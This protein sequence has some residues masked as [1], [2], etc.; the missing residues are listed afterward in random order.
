[1]TARHLTFAG[2]QGNALAAS[3]WPG[4]TGAPIVLFTHGGG[5]TRHAWDKTARQLAGVGLSAISIDQRGHGDS[6]WVENGAYAVSDF[7]ADLSSV[8]QAIEARFGRKPISVGASLG[9]LASMRAIVDRPDLFEALILVDITPRMDPAGVGHIQGFMRAKAREG[10][11]SIE[12]AGEAVARY[13]PHRPRP[14]SLEGLRKNLR[15]GADGRWRWHWDPLFLDGPRTINHDGQAELAKVETF[16]PHYRAPTLLV[17]GAA[18]E[19][20]TQEA[21]DQFMALVPHAAYADVADARH[22]VAGDRNDHFTQA[23]LAFLKPTAT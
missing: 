15:Q 10:F 14:S 9:G 23:V 19:L 11:A 21:V 2:R 18:S 6:A 22:M 12:E 20:V 4:E 1:M 5:Q 8:V 3:H 13:L 7:A 16:L 17:R